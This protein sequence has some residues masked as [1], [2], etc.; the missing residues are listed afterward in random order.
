MESGAGVREV[1]GAV[2]EAWGVSGVRMSWGGG[3]KGVIEAWE[4]GR[5]KRGHGWC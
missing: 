5:N 1:V 2:K 3:L 4:S